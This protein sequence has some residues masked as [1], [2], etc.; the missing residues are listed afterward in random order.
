MT[1]A[2]A[3]TDG[4]SHAVLSSPTLPANTSTRLPTPLA[5]TQPANPTGGTTTNTSQDGNL[6]VVNYLV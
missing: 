3:L 4:G 5:P 2:P 1:I 6:H